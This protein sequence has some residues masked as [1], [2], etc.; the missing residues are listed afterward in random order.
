MG[1]LVKE[2]VE[3]RKGMEGNVRGKRRGEVREGEARENK[4]RESEEK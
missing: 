2:V 3:V 1:G 4:E